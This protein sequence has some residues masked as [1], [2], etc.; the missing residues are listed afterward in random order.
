MI[1][2]YI[3]TKRKIIFKTA[4]KSVLFSFQRN[5]ILRSSDLDVH[6]KTNNIIRQLTV[7][8]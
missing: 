2:L 3:R 1:I 4:A 7:T 6:N 5:N 8:S